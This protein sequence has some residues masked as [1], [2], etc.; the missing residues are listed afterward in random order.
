MVNKKDK[1]SLAPKIVI[2]D[3]KTEV[4][5]SEFYIPK[6]LNISNYNFDESGSIYIWD[7]YK[8]GEKIDHVDG[9]TIEESDHMTATRLYQNTAKVH[10]NEHTEKDGR[11][12]RRIVYGGHII[13]LVRML[14]FNGLNNA[15]RILAINGGKH[16]APTVAGDTIYAWT[17]ILDKKE[18]SNN[19]GVGVLRLKT[20]GVKN[21][22]CKEFPLY[23]NGDVEYN[24]NVVLEI[25]Y[26]VLIPKKL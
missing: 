25:D 21:H 16:I 8:V 1:S 18:L 14:S 7:D 17:E 23:K 13:S 22:L 10:F 26:S 6:D 20:I 15:F 9:M 19:P 11:L 3:L 12:G 4:D 5:N 2:P 24:S